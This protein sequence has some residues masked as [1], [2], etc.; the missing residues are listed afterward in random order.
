MTINKLIAAAAS[1]YPEAYVL[2]YW[3]AESREPKENSDGG[4]TLAFFIARELADTYDGA[5]TDMKKIET[6]ARKM[7]EAANDLQA[8]ADAL[9]GLKPGDTA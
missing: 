4:D 7:R 5:A 8:V 6:A 3:D 2:N 1:V 9:T